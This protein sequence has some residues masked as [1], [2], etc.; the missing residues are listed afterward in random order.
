MTSA[1][2]VID[3]YF[4]VHNAPALHPISHPPTHSPSL[5][6]CGGAVALADEVGVDVLYHTAAT[7]KA[8]L[9]VRMSG[10]PGASDA[11]LKSFVDKKML[12]RKTGAGFYL[13]ETS[14]K[15]KKSGSSGG[16]SSKRPLNPAAMAEIEPFRT[17]ASAG[18]SLES[19]VERMV[20]RFIKE[21]MHSLEDGVIKNAG[22][23]DIGAVF[24]LGFP[25]FLGGPFRY[26]DIMGPQRMADSM[27]R[28]A[29]SL[30][31]QFAP[32]AILLDLAKAGKKFHAA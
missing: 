17:Q 27:A 31:P 13:Y 29:D 26:A 30:G 12:G 7:M 8:A 5:P 15:G 16:G 25:P 18:V 19:A 10:G 32:P 28:Y 24:G 3:N 20:L 23:G 6:A 21:C 4:I 11:W 2:L 22:D 1:L 9:G 14:P